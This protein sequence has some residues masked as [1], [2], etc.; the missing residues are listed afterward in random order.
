M[1]QSFSLNANAQYDTVFNDL[2]LSDTVIEEI[3]NPPPP[4]EEDEYKDEEV[5]GIYFK[6]KDQYDTLQVAQ[7]KVPDS[8]KKGMQNDEAF[9]YANAE[10]EKAPEGKKGNK[11]YKPFGQQTWV[12][13]LFWILVIGVFAAVIMLYLADSNIGLFRKKKKLVQLEEEEIATEDIFAINYQ[14]EIEKAA[15]QANYRLAVRLM[16]LRLL[17]NMSEKNVINYKQD[18]T[19]F[20]YLLQLHPTN[21]YKD[22]FRIT[23]NYEYTWYGQFEINEDAYKIIR[24]DFDLFEKNLARN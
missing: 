4:P 13:T 21:Y 23:R 6:N 22:F 24:N 1:L 8:V 9:W 20:D 14:R 19:N 5:D 15:A 12:K 18:K 17:K 16:F 10:I 11:S 7:R 2:S 3:D